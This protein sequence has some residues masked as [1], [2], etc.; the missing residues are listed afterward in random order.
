MRTV[1]R[2]IERKQLEYNNRQQLALTNQ[3]LGNLL[4]DIRK[5]SLHLYDLCVA[6]GIIYPARAEALQWVANAY[7]EAAELDGCHPVNTIECYNNAVRM[8]RLKLDLDIVCNGHNSH[9][10]ENTLESLGEF[11]AHV[12]EQDGVA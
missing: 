11:C 4:Q 12:Q 10:V 1:Q 9:E 5:D 8:L 7:T 6:E 3:V 2:R